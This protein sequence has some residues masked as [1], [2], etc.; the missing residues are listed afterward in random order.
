VQTNLAYGDVMDDHPTAGPK[1]VVILTTPRLILRAATEQDVPFMQRLIFGDSEVM[2]YV[3]HGMPMPEAE[4]KQFM[5]EHFTFGDRLTG[6]AILT[7]KSADDVIGIA[8]LLP[9]EALGTDDFEI[10]FALARNAWGRGVA[11]EIG[12]AQ[13]AFGFERLNRSRLLGL[14]DPRNGPSIHTLEK[15]GLR[16]VN[17]V[18]KPKRGNRSVY[19]IEAQEWRN[20][21]A[22]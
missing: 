20:R 3:F 16:H 7:E 5:R 8:G 15:L 1:P 9:C 17:D 12:E 13:L 6:M 18:A 22:L 2:R 21:H 19:C 10:G 14:V 4:T 11:T